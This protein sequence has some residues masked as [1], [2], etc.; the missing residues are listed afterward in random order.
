MITIKRPPAPDFMTAPGNKWHKETQE[1]IAYYSNGPVDKAFKFSCYNDPLMKKALREVFP[2]CAYCE[3]IYDHVYDG[4][5]E[6]FR[7]KGRVQEKNPP[8]PGYYWLANDW[9]NLFLSCQH[10]N[11]RRSH[12][13]AGDEV[14][15][16]Y[17]KLDQFPLADELRRAHDHQAVM[18]DEEN[19]R[20][21]LNPCIDQP[22][23]HFRYDDEGEAV[24]QG[25]TERAHIS[26]KVYVLQ[27][28]LLVQER[29]KRLILLL[30]QINVTK[31][32]LE[33]FNADPSPGQRRIF[34][35]EY[36]YMMEFTK[37]NQPYAG[38]ARYFVRLF[39]TENGLL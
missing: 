12:Q 32:E 2:K 13:I 1:A 37:A 19:C 28:V 14:A 16:T 11:Q 27:R 6:H 23:K 26:I 20:L 30:R 10:C 34:R 17:G 39:L 36:N 29:K 38:M 7:P 24:I 25:L 5:V 18:A 21:L 3:S 22:E 35:E 4:D 9:D 15:R 33:R 8:S 31:R